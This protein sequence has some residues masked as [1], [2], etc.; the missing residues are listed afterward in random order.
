MPTSRLSLTVPAGFDFWRTVFSHGW[1]SL[2]PFSHD[3][4]LRQLERTLSLDSGSA[5]HVRL[6]GVE[7]RIRL[8]VSADKPLTGT[9]RADLKKQIATCLRLDE[10][11]GAFYT[12]VRKFPR[13]RWMARSGSGRIL[14]S[15]TVFEDAIKTLCT[16]NCTWALTQIM[17]RRIIETSGRRTSDGHIAFPSPKELAALSEGT[18][19][20]VC[21]TGY[22]A[23]FIKEF[24]ERVASGS[25][26][27]EL[28]R[29]W[30]GTTEDLELQIRQVKGM[31]P[32]AAGNLLRLLGRH[33]SLA[34]DSW[35]RGQFYRLHK[36]GRPVKDRV[37]ERHYEEFGK[38]RGLMFWLEMTR[39]W[40][41]EK[42]RL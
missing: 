2:L 19:R 14:R 30:E 16:T 33:D 42:F 20:R 31:G 24:V 15:P 8:A 1:C 23:P 17:V 28:W 11:L 34:L 37:I 9:D 5:V 35:V 7:G 18:L 32:Y 22:R 4:E 27:V 29:S 25:L 41:D 39:Y 40:H 3:P 6:T 38:W 10:D 36:R 21:T 12:F 13:Y 26:P